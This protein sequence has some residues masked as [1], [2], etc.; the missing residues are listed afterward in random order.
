MSYQVIHSSLGRYRI[1]VPQV[2]ID[3]EYATKIYWLVKSLDFVTGVR[4]NPVASSVIVNYD[5]DVVSTAVAQENVINCIQQANSAEIPVALA[6]IEQEVPQVDAWERLSLP[7]LSLGAAL[8]A[9]PFELSIPFLLIGGLIASAAVPVFNRAIAGLVD[10]RKFKVDVLDSLWITLQTL[11][12]QYLAAALMI[13]LAQ[14][15]A[16]VRD[17]SAIAD[18]RQLI[19]LLDSPNRQVEQDE[20]QRSCQSEDKPGPATNTQ[21][22]DYIEEVSDKLVVPT[23]LVSG[24]I[25]ALTGNLSPALAPLQLDFGTG[26]GIAVP[27]TIHAALTYAA[28]SNVYI[29]SGRALE[30]LSCT[31]TVIFGLN[32]SL[33]QE[34]ANSAS[35]TLTSQGIS[36]YMLTNDN[37]QAVNEVVR[38]LHKDGRVVAYVSSGSSDTS[39]ANE[40]DVSVCLAKETEDIKGFSADIVLIGDDLSQ[41]VY[42]IDIAKHAMKIVYQNVAIVAIP[43]ISV[44]IAGV[45]FGLHPVWAVLINNCAAFIAE[46]N[47]WSPLLGSDNPPWA[48]P[49]FGKPADEEGPAILLA[50][51]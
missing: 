46:L 37:Q 30:V 43:N 42:A 18:Q 32:S 15:G 6:T 31:D 28:R 5:A 10:E 19:E 47:G 23:L 50:P 39:I 9:G 14:T 1:R 21:I 41:L 44:A 45:F 16:T 13:N 2:A 4:I 25:F 24:G 12:G 38:G 40:V 26:I 33:T 22:G 48:I 35:R 11:Q 51:S 8:L 29:R 36:S 20:T 3:S 7:I 27:T 17:M 49:D 34:I